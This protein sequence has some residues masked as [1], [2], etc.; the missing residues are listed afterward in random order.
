ME[1][2][3]SHPRRSPLDLQPW[4][5][6][7][8]Q[9]EPRNVPADQRNGLGVSSDSNTENGNSSNRGPVR[10]DRGDRLQLN[11][12]SIEPGGRKAGRHRRG[13]PAHVTAAPAVT[14]TGVRASADTRRGR[15]NAQ[16]AVAVRS[17][18]A[19]RGPA[20]SGVN[21]FPL[22]DERRTAGS[23]VGFR[24]AGGA[25]LTGHPHGDSGGQAGPVCPVAGGIWPCPLP[26]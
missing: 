13:R 5:R 26:H 12:S 23:E 24:A 21:S 15:A 16:D 8:E 11:T 2:P 6:P 3:A 17:P 22:D 9:E 1:G 18:V 25:E 10:E 14:A 7:G 20:A 19:A 4:P